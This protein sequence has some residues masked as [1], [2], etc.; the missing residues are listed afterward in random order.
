MANAYASTFVWAVV[1]LALSLI[2][3]LLRLRGGNT[4]AQQATGSA[5]PDE[6][7]RPEPV[8]DGDRR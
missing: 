1:L 3:A 4:P 6:P 7:R 5:T 8:S 2:P